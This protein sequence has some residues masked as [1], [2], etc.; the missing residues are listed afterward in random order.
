MYNEQHLKNIKILLT[1]KILS[2]NNNKK[3]IDPSKTSNFFQTD[4][5]SLNPNKYVLFFK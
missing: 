4:L 5:K 3:L 2:E 1:E